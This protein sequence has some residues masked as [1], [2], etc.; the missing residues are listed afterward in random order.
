M[1]AHD[2]FQAYILTLTPLAYW[3]FQGLAPGALHD[4]TG[5]GHDLTGHGTFTLANP[6]TLDGFESASLDGATA[7]FTAASP[8]A[9][10]VSPVTFGV[11][12]FPTSGP[13]IAL[14]TEKI[15]TE[16]EG[17]SIFTSDAAHSF[18]FGTRMDSAATQ[19]TVA[20]NVPFGARGAGYHLV[21]AVYDGLAASLSIDGTPI[22]A[23]ILANYAPGTQTFTLGAYADTQG[24]KLR[25]FISDA[26]VLDHAAS[27]SQLQN[28]AGLAGAS[29]ALPG[30]TGLD[31][32]NRI[33]KAVSTTF[34]ST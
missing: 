10:N 9:L 28:A 14:S 25:G 20:D 3:T 32:L 17:C 16:L 21:A 19:A 15:A 30:L 12:M 24:A 7:Y 4:V 29:G 11:I 18:A 31:L 1:T 23:G 26:F 2:D 8:A 22:N 6:T 5:H 33:L 27:I 13:Q 34:P